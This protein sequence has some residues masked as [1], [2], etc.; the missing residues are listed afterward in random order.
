M[1]QAQMEQ[2]KLS[3]RELKAETAKPLKN[4]LFCPISVSGSNLNPRNTKGIPVF[5]IITFLDLEQN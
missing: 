4:T 3:G 2:Q 1:R 5:K